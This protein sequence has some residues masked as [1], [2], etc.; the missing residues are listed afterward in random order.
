M[1]FILQ[2]LLNLLSF[3]GASFSFLARFP[4]SVDKLSLDIVEKFFV[5]QLNLI[6]DSISEIKVLI[7]LCFL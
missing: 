5:E 7:A 3:S 4:V 6:K 2:L 1:Y